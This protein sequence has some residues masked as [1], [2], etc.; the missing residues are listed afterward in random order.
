MATA[1]DPSPRLDALS[2]EANLFREIQ[3]GRARI[4]DLSILQIF[5]ETAQTFVDIL[6]ELFHVQTPADVIAIF[7]QQDRLIYVGIMM[8]FAAVFIM[9]TRS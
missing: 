6:D 5:Q 4:S 7:A 9:A 8:I 1:T 3:T 2:E